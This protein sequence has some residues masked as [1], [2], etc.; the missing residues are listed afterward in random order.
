MIIFLN[1]RSTNLDVSEKVK[2][3]LESIKSEG[4]KALSELTF[5]Y[6][7]YDIMKEGI[8]VDK[9]DIDVAYRECDKELVDAIE[10]V[11]IELVFS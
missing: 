2:I 5:K 3:I 9:K 11:M 10:K 4:D 7:N 6:D 1:N 8:C